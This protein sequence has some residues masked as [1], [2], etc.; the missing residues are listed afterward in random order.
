MISM[1]Q[2]W[3]GRDTKY[4]SEMTDDIASNAQATVDAVNQLLEIAGRSEDKVNSGWRPQ[5]V[6]DATRNAA[7]RSKHLT[8]QAVDIGDPDR[9]LA[10]WVADNLDVLTE[11]GLYCEDFR[12]TGD[13]D[14]GWV[15]FQTVPPKSG[16][17][18]FIPSMEPARD[19]YF[20]VTWA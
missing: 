8:G 19:P 13:A 5:A 20:P 18:I 17:R 3:M 9:S 15:H 6:N 14:G 12:W 11:C 1:T 10:T 4:A 2:Y 7:S 16:R